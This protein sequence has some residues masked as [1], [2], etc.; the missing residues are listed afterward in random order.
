MY[1]PTRKRI[2]RLAYFDE[3]TVHCDPFFLM[4][5]HSEAKIEGCDDW[6]NYYRREES[7]VRYHQN[8]L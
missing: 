1:L 7:E 3:N 4:S 2:P 8:V 6:Q 5:Q